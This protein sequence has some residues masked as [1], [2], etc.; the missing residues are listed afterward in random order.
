MV[1]KYCEVCTLEFT[2]QRSSAKYCS[3]RCKQSAKYMRQTG[4]VVDNLT[5]DMLSILLS[6]HR[7]HA[8]YFDDKHNPDV[9]LAQMDT[10]Q[11]I[12]H[13]LSKMEAQIAVIEIERQNTWYQ[14]ENCGQKSFGLPEK[15][16]YCSEIHF[17]RIK[18]LT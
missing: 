5:D 17:K 8:N 11:N 12:R 18:V 3:E 2:A 15:C 1:K 10:I 4:D 7:L 13:M 14:C 16:D 6:V 9:I